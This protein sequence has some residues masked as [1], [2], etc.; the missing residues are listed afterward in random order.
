MADKDYTELVDFLGKQFEN[1]RAE[2]AA[3]KDELRAEIATSKE[4]VLLHT[5]ILSEDVQ[6]KLRAEI[7]ASKEEVM[8][9]TGVLLEGVQHK[10]DILVEGR[11]ATHERIEMNKEENEREHARLEKMADI[12]SADI[13]MLDQRVG[14]LEGRT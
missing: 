13:S 7:V 14:R 12:H 5:G 10:F 6:R 8:R 4:D 1:I 3:T 2:I 11:T 9:H